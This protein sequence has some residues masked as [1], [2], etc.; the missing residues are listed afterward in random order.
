MI[1]RR[2]FDAMFSQFREER[3]AMRNYPETGS[4]HTLNSD[5]GQGLSIVTQ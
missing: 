1:A 5:A 4:E 2:R 3:L